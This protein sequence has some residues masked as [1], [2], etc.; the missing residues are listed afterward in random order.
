MPALIA[1]SEKVCGLE[2]G[3]ARRP[4]SD[5][6]AAI[7]SLIEEIRIA[8]WKTAPERELAQRL[9]IRLERLLWKE[10]DTRAKKGKEAPA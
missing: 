4:D 8:P 9:V 3:A 5:G 7:Q 2:H 1:F 10:E 6:V